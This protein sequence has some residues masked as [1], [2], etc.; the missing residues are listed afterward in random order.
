MLLTDYDESAVKLARGALSKISKFYNKG[1][2]LPPIQAPA[3]GLL[4]H[5]TAAEGLK[6]IIENNE[7]WASSAYFLNDSTEVIYGYGL[8]KEAL[9]E[10]IAN[11]PRPE[12]SLSLE[13]ARDFRRS[14]DEDLLNVGNIRPIYL[15]CFCEQDNLLSQWR[16][17]GQSGG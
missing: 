6:G 14:F 4:F 1:N 2:I 13:I 5:Y 3:T 16:T 12:V 10:W 11:N 9:V 17:Y 15:A 8:L 7:L